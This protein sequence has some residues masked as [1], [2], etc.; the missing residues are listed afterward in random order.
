MGLRSNLDSWDYVAGPLTLTAGGFAVYCGPFVAR[1]TPPGGIYGWWLTGQV[2]ATVVAAGLPTYSAIRAKRRESRAAQREI[3]ARTQARIEMNEALDPIVR[4][5]ASGA[6]GLQERVL[7]MVVKTAAEIIGPDRGTRSCYF[8][9][10]AGPPKKLAPT[11]YHAG[12]VGSPRST[13]VEGN[14]GGNDAIAMVESNGHRFCRNT[15]TSHPPGWSNKERDQILNN[16]SSYY[17]EA[18]QRAREA[19]EREV[20]RERAE[21]R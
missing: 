13:F 19:V 1:P 7:W 4:S 9:L 8:D 21:H 15:V 10:Q 16:P 6:P 18:R 17:A 14:W 3:D 12:R 20:A 11:I 5:L 2:L